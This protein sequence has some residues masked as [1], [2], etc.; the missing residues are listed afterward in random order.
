M[1]VAPDYVPNKRKSRE[2]SSVPIYIFVVIDTVFNFKLEDI[3]LFT[4]VTP[5]IYNQPLWFVVG[6]ACTPIAAYNPYRI[7][8]FLPKIKEMGDRENKLIW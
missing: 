2:G 8:Q 5:W 1:E 3:G 6:M 7:L 4:T